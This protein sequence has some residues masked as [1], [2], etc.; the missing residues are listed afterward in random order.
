MLNTPKYF[1]AN[2]KQNEEAREKSMF[3]AL[4]NRLLRQRGFGAGKI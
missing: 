1:N 2:Y 3:I 4:K